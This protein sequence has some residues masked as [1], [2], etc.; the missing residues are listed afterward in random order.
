M[1]VEL[2]GSSMVGDIIIEA[3]PE[4][5]FEALVSPGELEQWWGQDGM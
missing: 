5:V 1:N 4:V 3:A 2:S